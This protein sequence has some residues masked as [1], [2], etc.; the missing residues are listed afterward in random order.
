MPTSGIWAQKSGDFVPKDDF[1]LDQAGYDAALAYVAVTGGV[2][3]LG[4]D[5]ILQGLILRNVP[6]NTSVIFLRND[7][8]MALQCV[9]LLRS[10]T[11]AS[12]RGRFAP[13]TT[14]LNISHFDDIGAV[15]LPVSFGLGRYVSISPTRISLVAAQELGLVGAPGAVGQAVISRG[16]GL[17]PQWAT[18][19]NALLDGANHTDTLAGAVASGDLIHGNATPKW[20]RLAKG[21]DGQVLTLVGGL[22]AWASAGASLLEHNAL[23]HLKPFQVANC[24]I[25]NGSNHLTTGTANGFANV[26]VGDFVRFDV[27]TTSVWGARVTGLN[28]TTDV[29]LDLTNTGSTQS[30]RLCT[31][32]PGD[33]WDDTIGTGL[34]IAAGRGTYDAAATPG[35]TLQELRGS[36]NWEGYESGHAADFRVIGSNST[37]T[38]FGF[39][40]RKQGT[41]NKVYFHVNDITGGI[42]LRI[43]NPASGSFLMYQSGSSQAII[44]SS[45]LSATRSLIVRDYPGTIPVDQAVATIL[46]ATP[47]VAGG[48]GFKVTNAGAVNMTDLTGGYDN[49][50][51]KL[52][53]TNG[54]TTLKD[55]STGGSFELS[56]SV[57]FTPVANTTMRFWRVNADAKWYEMSR[58]PN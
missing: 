22:P 24:G 35:G 41:G 14:D 38:P 1:S 46:G 9:L 19:V 52:L 37:V 36:F 20:A 2:V 56:G 7:G 42:V 13:S 8:N 15:E 16:A 57:D 25:A 10:R 28:S 54:N 27:M 39:A 11:D 32:I 53:F 12:F 44:D 40:I 23:F 49:Q 29:T 45:G 34:V 48:N 4:P 43:G 30:G 58:S 6:S 50:E 51:V 33:H 5:P 26:R 17:S 31:V 21:S 55:T 47:S 3:Q 18:I